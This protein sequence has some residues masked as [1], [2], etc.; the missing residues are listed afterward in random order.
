MGGPGEFTAEASQLLALEAKLQVQ[1]G[2]HH[3]QA[4]NHVHRSKT[5]TCVLC[6]PPAP[7][8]ASKDVHIGNASSALSR[9]QDLRMPLSQGPEQARNKGQCDSEPHVGPWQ[10]P[11]VSPPATDQVLLRE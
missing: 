1:L 9:W 5:S 3:D 6:L 7:G 2:D 11:A 10:T 4:A 8:Y